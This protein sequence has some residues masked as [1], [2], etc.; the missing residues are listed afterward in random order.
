VAILDEILNDIYTVATQLEKHPNTLARG[1]YLQNGKFGETVLKKFGGYAAVL[2]DAFGTEQADHMVVRAQANRKSYVSKLERSLG[3]RDYFTSKFVTSLEQIAKRNPLPAPPSKFQV[4]KV[5]GKR[6]ENVAFISDTHFGLRIDRQEVASNEYSWVVAARRMAKFAEQIAS[7][8]EEHRGEC[9][10]LRLCLGGDL[11]Q[12]V[13]HLSE[14]G[15]DLMVH[16]LYG[17]LWILTQMIEH[18]RQRYPQIKVECTSDNHM[19]FVHKG[20]DRATAQKYDG[21]STLLHMGLQ[22]RFATCPDVTFNIPKTPYTEFEVLGHHFFM[23]HGD[24]VLRS[25]NVGRTV[26]VAKITN[27]VRALVANDPAKRIAAVLLGHV[28]VP[29][30]TILDNGVELIVNGSGSGTDAYAQSI[31]IHSSNPT[32]V[33]FEATEQFAVGDFRKVSLKDAD[34]EERFDK[35][36]RPYEGQLKVP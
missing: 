3:D 6:R 5:T 19:R 17:A 15:T 21:F 12:G 13:I 20:P 16:Q 8:K 33:M 11:C 25:G 7:Y 9:G 34:H 14:A 31:G 35:I 26:N 27:D 24:T 29:L 36:I 22:A 28:H 4:R 1:E 30:N 2:K 23:T 10:Q 32:Q 18:L